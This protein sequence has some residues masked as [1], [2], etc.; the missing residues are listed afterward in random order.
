LAVIVRGSII[1]WQLSLKKKSDSA[2]LTFVWMY[3]CIICHRNMQVSLNFI[4]LWVLEFWQSYPSLTYLKKRFSFYSLSHNYSC[5]SWTHLIWIWYM[6]TSKNYAGQVQIW[7]WS[8]D[9]LQG[10]SFLK[11][12]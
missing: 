7:S 2:L 11:N 6:D 4:I 8:L 10:Y 5:I 12:V 1:F 9:F 3:R